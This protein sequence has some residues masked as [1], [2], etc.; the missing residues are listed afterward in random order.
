MSITL[1]ADKLAYNVEE[2]AATTGLSVSFWNAAIRTGQLVAKT[3]KKRGE[4]SARG[5][6]RVILAAE[7]QR[8]L[9]EMDEVD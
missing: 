7:L 2:A 4:N 1:P 6:K 8:F 9:D 5:G 3:T